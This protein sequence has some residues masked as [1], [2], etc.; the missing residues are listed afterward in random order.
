MTRGAERRVGV[1]A[2]SVRAWRTRRHARTGQTDRLFP[3]E[4]PTTTIEDTAGHPQR[5]SLSSRFAT[6]HGPSRGRAGPSSPQGGGPTAHHLRRAPRV[7]RALRMSRGGLAELACPW[8]SSTDTRWGEVMW[9]LVG[10]SAQRGSSS[11]RRWAR[12]EYLPGTV[13]E[14]ALPARSSRMGMGARF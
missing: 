6:C 3:A 2:S 12:P 13:A 1:R 5:L 11:T 8:C 9:G 14:S 7:L 4:P 10:V